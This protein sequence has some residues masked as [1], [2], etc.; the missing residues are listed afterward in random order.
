MVFLTA[1]VF[2]TGAVFWLWG[3]IETRDATVQ[4]ASTLGVD[5]AAAR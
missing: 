1:G 4:L 5:P 2:I 3:T